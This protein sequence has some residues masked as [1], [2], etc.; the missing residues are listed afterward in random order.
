MGVGYNCHHV[1]CSVECS[2]NCSNVYYSYLLDSCSYC[3]GCIGLKNKQFCVFNEQYEKE[4]WFA[5]VDELFT[6]MEHQGDLGKTFPATMSPFYFND[7]VAY[8]IDPTFTK[9]EVTAAGY[10][11][12]DAPVQVDIPAEAELISVDELEKYER[13]QDDTRYI[14]PAILTK[15]IHDDEGNVYRIVK[16][17]Y[18][19]LMK[20]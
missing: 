6:D 2:P 1:Y 5:K 8:L 12:R 9:E 10:L 17:E 18:E 15:I 14:D 4:A 20:Q 7:T 3:F 16:M 13:Y 19:F 11:R